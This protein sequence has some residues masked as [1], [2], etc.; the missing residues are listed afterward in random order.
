MSSSQNTGI[1][2]IVIT[3]I[4]ALLGT[5]VSSG[6]NGHWNTQLKEKEFKSQ[7]IM[8]ALESSNAQERRD[9]LRFLINA[10]LID[11][12][13]GLKK[14]IESGEDNE[15]NKLLDLPQ[16]RT[17]QRDF[18]RTDIDLWYCQGSEIGEIA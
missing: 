6:L 5:A 13:E 12:T 10:E 15:D 1:W 16:L 2:G 3:G 18:T 14:Y 7:L 8:K 4:L 9:F 11:T 17:S